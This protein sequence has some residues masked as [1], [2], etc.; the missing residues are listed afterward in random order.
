MNAIMPKKEVRD[1]II[2]VKNLEKKFGDNHVLKGIDL[3]VKRGEVVA[4]IGSSGSGKSTLLR[5]LNRLERSSSGTVIVD[6][7]CLTESNKNISII[8]QEVGMVFQQFNLFP[9]MTVLDNVTIG[10][11]Q[12]LRKKKEEAEKEAIVLLEKVGLADK[13]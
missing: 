8:R 3:I 13:R 7:V 9:H 6:D 11:I 1:Q 2:Q 5:C 12:V 10:P 4:L